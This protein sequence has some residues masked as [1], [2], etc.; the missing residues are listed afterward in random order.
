MPARWETTD[1][2]TRGTDARAIGL[3]AGSD[4]ARPPGWRE[5]GRPTRRSRL[6]RLGLGVQQKARGSVALPLPPRSNTGRSNP[7]GEKTMHVPWE[8]HEACSAMS[9]ASPASR[10]GSAAAG[11]LA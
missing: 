1:G 5:T 11:A 10:P 8:Q 3:G 2:V 7:R 6:A 4:L 9:L